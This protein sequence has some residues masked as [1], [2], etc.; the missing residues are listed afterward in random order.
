MNLP[1]YEHPPI[2]RAF[3]AVAAAAARHR[4]A[5]LESEI[6][7]LLPAAAMDGITPEDLQLTGFRDDQVLENR[8]RR[9]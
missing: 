3:D 8:L 5:V 7:G 2:R 4:V 9:L 6:V 1:N